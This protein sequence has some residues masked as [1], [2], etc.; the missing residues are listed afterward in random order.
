MMDSS[1]KLAIRFWNNFETR[2]IIKL[3][4]GKEF[5]LFNLPFYYAGFI[6]KYLAAKL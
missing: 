2:D 1:A 5:T 3:P 6:E 4:N